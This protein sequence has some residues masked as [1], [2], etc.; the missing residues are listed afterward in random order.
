VLCVF[1]GLTSLSSAALRLL[2]ADA[3]RNDEHKEEKT[4]HVLPTFNLLY[5]GIF[6]RQFAFINIKIIS[7]FIK[8]Q[9]YINQEYNAKIVLR[10]QDSKLN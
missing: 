5:H 7:A 9:L 6:I 2:R 3:P 1:S 8:E 10:Q 4:F